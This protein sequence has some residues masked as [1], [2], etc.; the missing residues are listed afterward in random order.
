MGGYI[1]FLMRVF[2]G[3]LILMPN[4]E[5]QQLIDAFVIL[6]I[7]IHPRLWRLL[8]EGEVKTEVR[9]LALIWLDMNDRQLTKRCID[10]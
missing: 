6:R 2:Q 8:H 1:E 5:I 10:H 9:C 7:E 3:K 4:D